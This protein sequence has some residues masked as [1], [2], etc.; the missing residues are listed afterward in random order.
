[1]D[2]P[3]TIAAERDDEELAGGAREPAGTCFAIGEPAGRA[4]GGLGAGRSR[5]DDEVDPAVEPE[6]LQATIGTP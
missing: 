4:I 6:L 3:E 1:M 2:I 5:K